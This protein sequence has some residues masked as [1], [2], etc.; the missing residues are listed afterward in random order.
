M[1]IVFAAIIATILVLQTSGQ[2]LNS[3]QEF[4]E[5][6]R[7]NI[8]TI[9]PIEGIWSVS[10]T[11]K[12]IY[13]NEVI[14]SENT[15]QSETVAVIKKNDYYSTFNTDG[16]SFD[17][18]IKFYKTATFGIYLFNTYFKKSNSTA[19]GNAILTGN[20]L[21][22]FA[23]KMPDK[24]IKSRIGRNIPGTS[25]VTEYQ[26]IK[27]FPTEDEYNS[28]VSS[29]GTGFAID[30]DG[31]I[32]TNHHVVNGATNILIRGINGDF[33]KPLRAK[34]LLEDINNDL[35]ILKIDDTSFSSLGIVPFVISN[36]SSDAGSSVFCLG[37]PLR[38]TMGDE[39]KLTNGIISSKSGF[40]GDITTYQITAPVQPGNSGGPLFDDKGKLVGI[41]NAKHLGAENASYAIKV[42]YLLNLID[43]LPTLPKV[44]TI[45]TL[46]GKPL[47]EQVKIVKN[48]IYIIE[49]N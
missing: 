18:D 43:A 21:L 7:K 41:I 40:Q 8:S 5:Y 3:E 49:I 27:V 38:A 9:D 1:K 39:I 24:E 17:S 12:N 33:S 44:Q 2:G 46:E 34:V 36:K 4:K 25:I 20:G 13:Q 15:P 30:S 48:F 29:S 10:F 11:V 47:S 42:S 28:P 32:V 22:E 35:A 19:K 16:S 45:N 14:Q 26:W 37:Y 23:S 31:I 6:Y